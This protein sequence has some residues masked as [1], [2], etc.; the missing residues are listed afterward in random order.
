[1]CV[2]SHKFS[3]K[4]PLLHWD[5]RHACVEKVLGSDVCWAALLYLTSLQQYQ[6]QH[7]PANI[8]AF[9]AEKKQVFSP[10]A[11]EET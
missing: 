10:A 4:R 2:L 11:A 6:F 5:Q 7:L 9:L 3:Q 1:M 8:F